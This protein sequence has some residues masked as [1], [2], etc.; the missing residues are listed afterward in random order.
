MARHS[1][2]VQDDV[3][4][5]GPA[6]R[7]RPAVEHEPT[8]GP[9]GPLLEEGGRRRRDGLDLERPRVAEVGP[10][11]FPV[12]LALGWVRLAVDP[13]GCDPNLAGGH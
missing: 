13:I 8:P 6:D 11:R 10:A 3:V 9:V 2:I 7:K 1:A 5:G 4:V 12:R